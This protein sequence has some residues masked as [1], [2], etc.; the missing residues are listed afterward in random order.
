MLRPTK[1]ERLKYNV[2]Y[3]QDT[4]FSAHARLL[5]SKWRIEKGFPELKLGNLL[6]QISPNRQ[7]QTS[8]R[9]TSKF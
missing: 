6:T 7:N 9:R 8:L 4:E 1:D 3:P 2:D 5:Q